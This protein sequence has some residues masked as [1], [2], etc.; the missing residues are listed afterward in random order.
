MTTTNTRV[1]IHQHM[2]PYFLLSSNFL[3]LMNI[4]YF[5]ATDLFSVYHTLNI[6]YNVN[7]NEAVPA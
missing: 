4:I 1:A 6:Y 5:S 2:N 7:F 3:N